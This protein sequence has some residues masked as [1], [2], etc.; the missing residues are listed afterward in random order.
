M[1]DYYQQRQMREMREQ[2]RRNMLA[3]SRRSSKQGQAAADLEAEVL[4]LTLVNRALMD[5]LVDARVTTLDD[6][7]ERMR[8]L[9]L[10]D[11]ERDGGLD[12]DVVAEEL[13]VRKPKIDKAKRFAKSM[14]KKAGTGKKKQRKK[15]A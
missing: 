2:M 15:K 1:S 12:P 11:G 7:A 8:A 4:F 13:G 5:V 14:R 3:R 6:I 10:A 9:D